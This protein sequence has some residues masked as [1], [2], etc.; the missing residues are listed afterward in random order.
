MQT[1]PAGTPASYEE[2]FGDA[3]PFAGAKVWDDS[4]ASP[5][6]IT[7]LPGMIG[8][9]LPALNWDGFSWRVKIPGDPGI[10]Y[11]AKMYAFTSSSY[12]TLVDDEPQG[13]ES[14]IFLA[15]GGS[16]VGGVQLIGTIESIPQLVGTVESESELIGTIEE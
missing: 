7:N 6:Q 11:L 2:T 15:E 13:S 8:G 1:W 14:F 3:I 5:V 9:V 10:A 16:G 12:D 4:G